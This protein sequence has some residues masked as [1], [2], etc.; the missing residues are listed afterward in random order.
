MDKITIEIPKKS[1]YISPLRLT[2]S[3]LASVSN[4]T[5]DKIEDLKVILSEICVFFINNVKEN[6]KTLVI[7]YYIC[8]DKICIEITDN[9]DER[10]SKEAINENEMF[11]MIIDSLADYYSIDHEKN[12]VFFEI[13]K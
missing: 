6:Q 9:N 5:I 1:E 13:F 7:D 2:S 3:S 8:D 4:F 12:K 10:L 11:S